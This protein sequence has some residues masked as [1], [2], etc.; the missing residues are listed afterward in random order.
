MTDL[1]ADA[2]AYV[3]PRVVDVER[4]FE[5]IRHT[6]PNG[7]F[8]GPVSAPDRF[9]PGVGVLCQGWQS[10]DQDRQHRR[11][12]HLPC[13]F[14]SLAAVLPT[15]S[16]MTGAMPSALGRHAHAKPRAW[17]PAQRLIRRVTEYWAFVTAHVDARSI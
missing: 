10:Q 2:P 17:H 3:G 4:R 9:Q 15:F 11:S 13:E 6:G 1:D 12:D 5:V 14:A 7:W 8:A 16:L